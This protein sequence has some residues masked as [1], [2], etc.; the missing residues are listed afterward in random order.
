MTIGKLI[1]LTVVVVDGDVYLLQLRQ[2]AQ[3]ESG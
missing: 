1:N 2:D 3:E